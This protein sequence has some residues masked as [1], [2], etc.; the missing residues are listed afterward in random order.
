M[1]NSFNITVK[2]KMNVLKA[3][4]R[5]EARK[6]LCRNFQENSVSFHGWQSRFQDHVLW[7]GEVPS[8]ST[9]GFW[10]EQVQD[11]E[12]EADKF[13]FYHPT[14]NSKATDRFSGPCIGTHDQNTFS[15]GF[16]SFYR[17]FSDNF[18]FQNVVA[19]NPFFLVYFHVKRLLASCCRY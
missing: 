5:A 17:C 2:R 11:N 12:G 6:G 15:M 7:V 14:M 1:Q 13:E 18:H 10:T 4:K 19:D 9:V 3:E 16:G 8:H